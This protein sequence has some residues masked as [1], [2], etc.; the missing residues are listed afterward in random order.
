MSFEASYTSGATSARVTAG[1]VHLP[2]WGAPTAV[3]Q[4]AEDAPVPPS[5][6]L[7]LGDFSQVMTVEH[8]GAYGG[9]R[10]IWLVGGANGWKRTIRRQFYS[11]PSGV[12]LAAVLKDAAQLAGESVALGSDFAAR[13]VG[14]FWAR[15]EAPASRSLALTVGSSWWVDPLGVTQI[16]TRPTVP[17]VVD[18]D[19]VMPIRPELGSYTIATEDLA[20]WVPGATFTKPGIL[21]DVLTISSVSIVFGAK[22]RLEV[23][24]NL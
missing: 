7:V 1:R 9:A 11:D 19:P 15:E 6:V 10:G 8:T 21:D 23:L 17:I 2:A 20:T 24:V 22:L 4:V 14:Q 3:V 5:G 18:F 16:G 13:V 12:K